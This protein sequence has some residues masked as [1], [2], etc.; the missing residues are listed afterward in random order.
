MNCDLGEKKLVAILKNCNKLQTLHVNACRECLMSGRLLDDENDVKVLSE[1]LISLKELS[2]ASNRYLSDALFNR[3]V[4]IC[5]N[6]IS[7]SLTGCQIS[8]HSGLYNKFYP[9][10]NDS[11][12]HA[13]ES[14]LTFCNI[15]RFL[16]H[17]ARRLKYLS[18]GC[19]LI[20]GT[21]LTSLSTIENL[22]LESLKLH[23]CDQLTNVGIR[24][25]TEHQKNLKV[26][27]VSFCARVTD[28]SLVRICQN[29]VNLEVLNVRRC[30]AVT[31]HG[32]KQVR[33]L[34]HL[35]ELDISECEQ[36]TSECII[37][38]LCAADWKEDEENENNENLLEL[39]GEPAPATQAQKTLPQEQQRRVNNKLEKLY[40]N[41]LNLDS[42][43]ILSI[44]LN[45]PKLTLLD[46]GY[47]FNAVTD[48]SIQV[49]NH[50]DKMSYAKVK[51]KRK[52]P[53]NRRDFFSSIFF[54]FLFFCQ[55]QI[56]SMLFISDDI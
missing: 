23:G 12:Y 53:A 43:S 8:F 39:N 35:K 11:V 25:L 47:C 16:K 6:L 3:L 32:I 9:S 50:E 4:N 45:C 42:R 24:S 17:Q 10:S 34:K 26:L 48:S 29:L 41:A 49:K 55:K 28:A 51:E 21:A 13:S 30:R 44:A 20:D 56:E 27:D 15:L 40:A 52:E 18:F 33:R 46:V 14:V 54:F 37:G 2:L 5:P 38:G 7:L 31:D 1:K 22:E 19:T 36:L